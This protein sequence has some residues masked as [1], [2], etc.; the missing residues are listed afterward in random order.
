MP[1]TSNCKTRSPVSTC[2]CAAR[3]KQGLRCALPK[4]SLTSQSLPIPRTR[5]ETQVPSALSSS[6]C[7]EIVEEKASEPSGFAGPKEPTTRKPWCKNP[8]ESTSLYV[9]LPCPSVST[10]Y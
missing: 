8:T 2:C 6:L 10:S 1:P 9:K 4:M 5:E 3:D 7:P